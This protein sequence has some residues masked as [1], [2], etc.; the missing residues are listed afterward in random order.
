MALIHFC[1]PLSALSHPISNSSS[2]TFTYCRSVEGMRRH[3]QHYLYDTIHILQLSSTYY[4]S[5]VVH[6]H[7]S[8]DLNVIRSLPSESIHLSYRY[9]I[10]FPSI[11]MYI[12]YL[13]YIFRSQL[14]K[15]RCGVYGCSENRDVS[16]SATICWKN[17]LNFYTRYCLLLR[18]LPRPRQRYE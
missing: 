6:C 2:G 17:I 4:F 12:I 10:K 13:Q 7:P 15:M 1:H 11:L 16:A 18:F 9:H 3:F 14:S 5:S 8:M